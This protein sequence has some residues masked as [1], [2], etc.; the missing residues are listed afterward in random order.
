MIKIFNFIKDNIMVFLVA[1]MLIVLT[2][3]SA[4]IISERD[5]SAEATQQN[6]CDT[7]IKEVTEND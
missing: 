2:I 1:I 4:K 3:W 7:S 5:N 6:V